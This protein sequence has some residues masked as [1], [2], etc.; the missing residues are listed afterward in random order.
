VAVELHL[1][2][3]NNKKATEEETQPGSLPRTVLT[4]PFIPSQSEEHL[5]F[6]FHI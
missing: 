6:P 3:D 4:A 5:F 1:I 2:G